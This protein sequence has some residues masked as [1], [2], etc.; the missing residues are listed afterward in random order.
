MAMGSIIGIRILTTIYS[1]SILT[2]LRCYNKTV[3]KK[4]SRLLTRK[5]GNVQNSGKLTSYK[6]YD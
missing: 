2:V 6:K 1:R 3:H 4:H 5:S